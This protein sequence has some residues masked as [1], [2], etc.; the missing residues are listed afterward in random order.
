MIP[1]ESPEVTLT[2]LAQHPAVAPWL[3]RLSPDATPERIERAAEAAGLHLTRAELRLVE[4]VWARGERLVRDTGE[5]T[6]A[7]TTTWVPADGH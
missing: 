7:V 6:T 3:A 4:T 1:P 2:R 5:P